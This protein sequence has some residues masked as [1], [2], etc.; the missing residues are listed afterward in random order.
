M[1]HLSLSYMER[2]RITKVLETAPSE[3]KLTVCGWVR[4]FRNDR[5][6]AVNDGSTLRNLQLEAKKKILRMKF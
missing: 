4:T 5:F 3:E 1:G 2:L 6:L